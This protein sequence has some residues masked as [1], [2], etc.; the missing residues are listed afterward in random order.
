MKQTRAYWGHRD[1][2]I[3]AIAL[4]LLGVVAGMLRHTTAVADALSLPSSRPAIQSGFSRRVWVGEP[5]LLGYFEHP[6]DVQ[7]LALPS[8]AVHVVWEDGGWIYHAWQEPDGVWHAPTRIFF[9]ITPAVAFDQDNVIHMV[10][11]AKVVGNYEIYYTSFRDGHWSWPRPISFT[12]GA[13]YSPRLAVTIS[14]KGE[15]H[16]VWNDTS[17]GRDIIYHAVF[18]HDRNIWLNAPL[19]SARGKSPIIYVDREG[20]FHVVWQGPDA[21][22]VRNVFYMYCQGGRWALPRNV[23]HSTHPS[24]GAQSVLD[25][26]ENIHIVWKEM[27]YAGNA[28]YYTV[29]RGDHWLRPERITVGHVDHVGVA[30][31]EH[32]HFVHI[33]WYDGET[34]WE[35]WRPVNAP[36]W[37]ARIP[38]TQ[39]TA[40]QIYIRFALENDERLRAIW[41]IQ[42]SNGTEVWYGEAS[43]PVRQKFRFP[44]MLH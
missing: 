33:W 42:T 35:Q 18:D 8:G 22:G 12:P 7:V 37:S 20:T 24:T 13:S 39:Q 28:M 41:N 2:I 32:G 16:V 36:A 19:P 1:K 10:F 29:G 31:S 34:W 5:Q 23:S 30:T 4:F 43:T 27:T 11:V 14:P 26:Q 21:D 40:A 3:A 38:L 9:G 15:L 17:K 25:S 6:A 44:Y